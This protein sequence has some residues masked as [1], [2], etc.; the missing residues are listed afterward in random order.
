[1]MTPPVRPARKRQA[2]N[3]GNET[4]VDDAKNAS[5]A[6]TIIARNDAAAPKRAAAVRASN[7]P[8]R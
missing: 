3:Q 7:A 2:K 1:M 5:V 6:S 4:G 8:A